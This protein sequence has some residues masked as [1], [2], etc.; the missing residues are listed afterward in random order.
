MKGYY[1]KLRVKTCRGLSVIMLLSSVSANPQVLAEE[2]HGLGGLP[3]QTNASVLSDDAASAASLDSAVS[4]SIIKILDSASDVTV[5]DVVSFSEG[6]TGGSIKFDKSTGTITGCDSTVTSAVIP[7]EIEGVAVTSIGDSAFYYKTSLTDV[8]IPDTVTKIGANSFYNCTALK[9]VS[10]AENV[11]SVG[12]NAFYSSGLT[13]ISLPSLVTV[14]DYSFY[15]AGMS[16]IGDTPNLKSIGNAAFYYSKIGAITLPDSVSYIGN[17]AFYSCSNLKIYCNYNS[18]AHIYAQAKNLNYE[19]IDNLLTYGVTGGNIYIE[20]NTGFI[21]KCDKSVISAIIPEIIGGVEIRG[22]GKNA[23]DGCTALTELILPD[24]ITKIQSY[25]ISNCDAIKTLRLPEGLTALESYA[26]NGCD[27]VKSLELPE[28]MTSIANSAIYRCSALK[29]LTINGSLAV[30]SKA[31]NYC[32]NLN[33]VVFGDG[34]TSIAQYAVYQANL[35]SIVI[36]KTV[37]E[38][39]DNAFNNYSSYFNSINK[40]LVECC[41]ETAGEEYA[42][43]NKIRYKLIDDGITIPVDDGSGNIYVSATS[44]KITG[45]DLGVKS[46][47][48]N[49]T[50]DGVTI[51]SVGNASFRYCTGL[52][53]A[54]FD[55]NVREFEDGC[56][57][58]CSSL[59]KITIMCKDA[60]VQ[61][62]LLSGSPNAVVYCTSGS[63][64]E[65]Y[66]KSYNRSYVCV[67]GEY[68]YEV[69]GGFI[70]VDLSRGEIVGFSGTPTAVEIPEEIKGVS[71]VGVAKNAFKDCTSLKSLTLPDTV[72]KI[73][74]YAFSGCNYM[75]LT[76]LPKSVESIGERA[77]YSCSGI[78][79]SEIP[80]SVS[81]IGAYAFANS[82]IESMYIG[83][84]ID[85]LPEYVFYNCDRLRSV[86]VTNTSSISSYVFYDCD[87]LESV[88]F[89]DNIESIGDYAFAYCETLQMT[90]L[91]ATITS[92]GNY[93]FYYCSLLAISNIPDGV[94]AIGTYTFAYTGIESISIGTGLET[95]TGFVGCSKLKSAELSN[96]KYIGSYAFNGCTALESVTFSNDI[97]SIGD[98]AF[99]GCKVLRLTTLPETLTSI[100]SYAFRNCAVVKI[101]KIPDSV[102]SI[103]SGAFA[104]SGIES[105][106]IGSGMTTV[107]GFG[108]CTN[109]K[110]VDASNASAIGQYAFSGCTALEN[111]KLSDEL[112]S[113]SSYAFSGCKAL[114]LS[115]LPEKLNIIGGYAFSNSGIESIHMGDCV[116]YVGGYSF[117]NCTNLKNVTMSAVTQINEYA[118]YNC[119]SLESID[120]PKTLI[121]IGAYAFSGDTSLK[122]VKLEEGVK[123]IYSYAFRN[124]TGLTDVYVYEETQTFYT[125]VFSN[126]S[127]DLTIHCKAG[128]SAQTYAKN[129]SINYVTFTEEEL[130]GTAI[131]VQG[132]NIYV[133]K[134]TGTII[135]ADNT[136]E[137]LDLTTSVG[138]LEIKA[139]ADKAF[140]N[141]INLTTVKLGTAVKVGYRSFYGCSAI[142]KLSLDSVQE[143]G[144]YAFYDCDALTGVT[145]PATVQK[146]G[147]SAFRNCS[148]VDNICI[149]GSPE[150]GAYIFANCGSLK[151]VELADTVKT[152]ASHAFYYCTSL[153][154]VNL[155][156]VETIGDGAFYD[157]CSLTSLVMPD[158]VKT[159]GNY[160]F[161]YCYRIKEINLNKVETIGNGAFEYCSA[162]TSIVIPDNVTS[163]GYSTFYCC[164][165]LTSITIPDSVKQIGNYAFYNCDSLKEISL[166]K[167]ET[168]GDRVFY[169]CDSLNGIVI[170]DSVTSI[171]ESVFYYCT[172][173]TSVTIPDS[174]KQIGSNAFYNCYSLKEINLNKV[175]TIGDYAF[176]GCGALTNVVL[177]NTV[178]SIGNYAFCSCNSLSEL[179]LGSVENIGNYAFE[180][181]TL[182]TSVTIP[183]TLKVI[184]YGVFYGCSSLKEINLNTVEKINDSAFSNCTSLK[185]V[186]IPDTVTYIG[187]YA[188]SG[189]SALESISIPDS[190][191]QIGDYCFNGSYKTVIHCSK[192]SYAETYAKA[193]SIK[194]STDEDVIEYSLEG[195]KI[196]IDPQTGVIINAD[197]T[198]TKA[199]I[200]A[201]IEGVKIVDLGNV[202]AGNTVLTEVH[203]PSTVTSIG[204]RE[205]YGCS[206]LKSIELSDGIQTI[207]DYAFYN[208]GLS[209]ITIPDSV[210]DIGNY[211]FEYCSSL[212][213]VKLGNGVE[214]IGNYAF[215]YCSSLSEV[216]LGN[217]VE[218]IGGYAFAYCSNLKQFDLGRNVKTIG[219]NIFY[220][221]GVTEALIPRSVTSIGSYLFGNS[222]IGMLYVYPDSYGLSYASSSNY[223]YK[224]VYDVSVS[225]DGSGSIEPC[226]IVPVAYGES[227]TLNLKPE[228]G[229]DSNVAKVVV[230]G[231]SGKQVYTSGITDSITIDDI[232]ESKTVS[233]VFTSQDIIPV[234]DI[235]LEES[236]IVLE[237]GS[238]SKKINYMVY[239]ED[240]T[241]NDVLFASRDSS[242][243]SVSADGVATARSIGETSFICASGDGSVTKEIKVYVKD[244]TKPVFYTKPEA[245]I[246]AGTTVGLKWGGAGDASGIEKYVVL[247]DGVKVGE[248]TALSYLDTDLTVDTTYVYEVMAVDN[249]GNE[250]EKH[251]VTVT[252]ITPSGSIQAYPVSGTI[253]GGANPTQIGVITS[254]LASN[255]SLTLSVRYSNGSSWISVPQTDILGV[256][257]TGT[258]ETKLA[259]KFDTSKLASGA[260]NVKFIVTGS[261]KSDETDVVYIVD[262]DAPAAPKSVSGTPGELMNTITWDE[263]LN[264]DTAGYFVYRSDSA[265]GSFVKIAKREGRG[266]NYY[267]DKPLEAGKTYYYYVTSYDN[268]DQEG[269]A[270]EVIGLTVL[271]DTKAPQILGLK[272]NGKDNQG[273][274]VAGNI[275]VQVK[276]VDNYKVGRIE[277][278]YSL[279]GGK[280]YTSLASRNTA[281]NEEVTETFVVNTK[282]FDSNTVTF[283]VI[284]EDYY[285]NITYGEDTYTF[286][287]DNIPPEKVTGLRAEVKSTIVTLNWN[288]VTADDFFCFIVEEKT[289]GSFKEIKRISDA[290]GCN[291]TKA[292]PEKVYSYRVCACDIYGNK[293]EYSQE[294]TITTQKDTFS[295]VVKDISPKQSAH[296]GKINVAVSVEDDYAVDYVEIQTSADEQNWQTFVVEDV[297]TSDSACVVKTVIDVSDME[298]GNLF[299]RAVPVDYAGNR[300]D[301]TN[302]TYV[303]YIIDHTAPDAP[304]GVS[305]K[306]ENGSIKVTWANPG[307]DV[308]AFDV[309]KAEREDGAYIRI[310]NKAAVLGI[311]DNNCIREKNYYYYVVAYDAAGN[312]SEKSAIV[313]A[314]V[315]KDTEPPVVSDIYPVSGST[316]AKSSIISVL[317]TDNDCISEA[318]VQYLDNNMQWQD[319]E[320]ENISADAYVI[321]FNVTDEMVSGQAISLRANATDCN[322]N[323]G[324]YKEFGYNV[325]T[326]S[327]VISSFT[328]TPGVES[329]DLFA[330]YADDDIVAIHIY[331][332]DEKN[333]D[334][335]YSLIE[336]IAPAEDGSKTISFTDKSVS[337]STTYSY[338]LVLYNSIGNDSYR[339]VNAVKPV[340]LTAENDKVKPVAVITAPSVVIVGAE[341]YFDASKSS[342]NFGI[343]SYKWDFGDGS[344]S[345]ALKPV[346]AFTQSG[347]Y[348]VKLT[349]TDVAGNTDTAEVSV[350]VQDEDKMGSVTIKVIDNYGDAVAN[351]GVYVNLGSENMY[352][353]STD[354]KGEYKLV[355]EEGKYSVGV[356]SDGYLPA[357]TSVFVTAKEDKA[358]IISIKKEPLVVGELTHRK[359]SLEEIKAAGI[360]ITKDENKYVYNYTVTFKIEETS[361][362]YNYQANNKR[363]Y[364]SPEIIL[365]PGV[366]YIVRAQHVGPGTGNKPPRTIVTLIKIPGSISWVKDF[367]EVELTVVNQ[368]D[369]EFY[370]KDSAVNLNVP[371]G[372]T[373]VE[374]NGYCNA[375]QEVFG[376][377]YGGASHT[378]KWVVRGDKD[379]SYDISADFD[380]VLADFN[381]P[382]HFEFKADEPIVVDGASNLKMTV[383][384]EEIVGGEFDYAMKVGITNMSGES[385]SMQTMDSKVLGL[386]SVE[387][388]K[389]TKN[390]TLTENNLTTLE[391]GETLWNNYIIPAELYDTIFEKGNPNV[392]HKVSGQSTARRKVTQSIS[393]SAGSNVELPSSLET[394][395]MFSFCRDQIDVYK[396]EGGSIGEEISQVVIKNNSLDGDYSVTQ[397]AY[398][399]RVRRELYNGDLVPI[400]TDVRIKGN[401]G[402]VREYITNEDGYVYVDSIK[403]DYTEDDWDLNNNLHSVSDL[404]N[405]YAIKTG[406]GFKNISFVCKDER[407][408]EGR[409]TGTL[410]GIKDGK[411]IPASG[412]TITALGVSTV[413]DDMGKF[414]LVT[415]MKGRTQVSIKGKYEDVTYNRVVWIRIDEKTSEQITIAFKSGGAMTHFDEGWMKIAGKTY[416]KVVLPSVGIKEFIDIEVPV[417]VVKTND[418]YKIKSIEGY[419]RHKDGTTDSLPA[420]TN[421]TNMVGKY[422]DQLGEN[423]MLR[424][425]TRTEEFVPGDKIEYEM[426]LQSDDGTEIPVWGTPDFCVAK[427]LNMMEQEVSYSI[428][429]S[430]SEFSIGNCKVEFDMDKYNELVGNSGA[431]NIGNNAPSDGNAAGQVADKIN[432]G[433]AL[434][435]KSINFGKT[436]SGKYDLSGEYVFTKTQG[437]SADILEYKL[438]DSLEVGGEITQELHFAY[439]EE[440]DDW[441]LYHN[442]SVAGNAELGIEFP[443]IPVYAIELEI[444]LDVEGEVKVTWETGNTARISDATIKN[445]CVPNAVEGTIGLTATAIAQV[446]GGLLGAGAY[447]GGSV[448]LELNEMRYNSKYHRVKAGLNCGFV[449]KLLWMEFSQECYDNEWVVYDSR[450]DRYKALS[451]LGQV[452]DDVKAFSADTVQNAEERSW[453]G[454][455][456][457]AEKSTVMTGAYANNNLSVIE[458]DNGTQLMTF[459]DY[460]DNDTANPL[461]LKYSINENGSWSTPQVVCEDG[462]VDMTPVLEKTASGARVMWVNMND[463]L[464]ESEEKMSRQDIQDNYLSRLGVY[465]ADFDAQAGTWSTQSRVSDEGKFGYSPV[466]ATDGTTVMTAY[467]T[468]EGLN[469]TSESPAQLRFVYTSGDDVVSSGAISFNGYSV[470]DVNI[471]YD[472]NGY[473]LV[474]RDDAAS[475][476]YVTKYGANGWSYPKRIS[477]NNCEEKFAS[478]VKVD[479]K[480]VLYYVKDNAIYCK[481]LTDNTDEDVIISGDLTKDIG[482]LSVFVDKQGTEVTLGWY[483]CVDGIYQIAV[484]RYDEA[485]SCY[486]EGIVV[487]ELDA[488]TVPMGIEVVVG[489]DGINVYYTTMTL[490]DNDQEDTRIEH[491]FLPMYADLTPESVDCIN[492]V[493]G[494]ESEIMVDISNLGLAAG[495][496]YTVMIADNAN[497]DNPIASTQDNSVIVSGGKSRAYLSF[498][499]PNVKD[500]TMPELYVVVKSTND[501]N[502][503]NDYISVDAGV[504]NLEIVE[505]KLYE[506]FETTAVVNVRNNSVYNSEPVKVVARSAKTQNVICEKV[507]DGISA[508]ES[509]DV[510]LV[511]GDLP[512]ECYN[513]NGKAVIMLSVESLNDAGSK[514]YDTDML[515]VSKS[516]DG[517]T[518]LA[519]KTYALIAAIGEVDENDA[520]KLREIAANL[521]IMTDEEL[522]YLTNL[523]VYT[524][525]KEEYESLYGALSIYY[526]DVDNDRKVLANDAAMALQYVLDKEGFVLDEAGLERADVDGSGLV[527]SNDAALILQKALNNRFVL[528]VEHAA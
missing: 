485:N 471:G 306:Q 465:S 248:T 123:Y 341:N 510:E 448:G 477:P 301:E 461:R 112:T 283:K 386:N 263:G 519:K 85:V 492:I 25:G 503:E 260:Y 121:S 126:C 514:E 235:E 252:T 391:K 257:Y 219:Y 500:N 63:T 43:T 409:L 452:D 473:C 64:V 161:Y 244:T 163:I 230:S 388:Y 370:I 17:N 79:I 322:G 67:D 198:I 475:L 389:E 258:T 158:S 200:P 436:Y 124:C 484:S 119:T 201:E 371:N 10:G 393:T 218:T 236:E 186:T 281:Q 402:T 423:P 40:A 444:S 468:S 323:V 88:E 526:G 145:I 159:I 291:I 250:S 224:L 203:I 480:L 108:N 134:S 498:I 288:D 94:T 513:E 394:T 12:N 106:Y 48:I 435:I 308:T 324:E 433:S 405:S 427:A 68:M 36:P 115:T 296:N 516:V 307:G 505:K 89:S 120:F 345:I 66:C 349:V 256:V 476:I 97:E 245:S 368:A 511:L 70:Q 390:G 287:I 57:A 210:T 382:V 354:Y 313:T 428:G 326:K 432:N 193:N 56:F 344:T 65:E 49:G 83:T 458:L 71:I 73:G 527:S 152:I 98:N 197:S 279:D 486:G 129:N 18:Y 457:K 45:A 231:A 104:Y 439:N 419:V 228:E 7:A 366:R 426:I 13:D 149:N 59:N 229:S 37:Q 137:V 267:V 220:S 192:G 271:E 246:V 24:T 378:N 499:M 5:S 478:L 215:A 239:P 269:E 277:L 268:F 31:V 447:L 311:Y 520:D 348:T 407:N 509:Q 450:G 127:T 90:E 504:T 342:D 460:V 270:G 135:Y 351:A 284:C 383:V 84:G 173:L 357:K 22:V 377:F 81:S 188:F 62:N 110:S 39:S 456:G 273:F 343:A 293:G 434:K 96:A 11:E 247:R 243:A 233:V 373:I 155:N 105:I 265:D 443:P 523:D 337:S 51:T 142:K 429:T 365:G 174:V 58:N 290:R 329:V 162:L 190:V 30:P 185:S 223:R 86:K 144:E 280:T 286:R 355:E 440:E 109:L 164:S 53:E 132:G 238:K 305:A 87:L 150:M 91:P 350:R 251:T 170:P 208:L 381:E 1:K 52:T 303:Q 334:G 470:A 401:D 396:Y 227:L 2:R 408:G 107:T 222:S 214:T 276:A 400:R 181:C 493:P 143:I 133:D 274:T 42:K 336:T 264:A 328:C 6:V 489:A 466:S 482:G 304:S 496:N 266:N 453:D 179:N 462:T 300:G 216:K 338:K 314:A 410:I 196:Y 367:F 298:D 392:Q 195:G 438:I 506:Y 417:I 122:S 46:V 495:S 113:I 497:G 47:D 375:S 23:F 358:E 78:K 80:D 332:A 74:D 138:G 442:T 101:E 335:Q 418:R 125:S 317:F 441:Y 72:K 27:M 515:L 385:V 312:V 9:S 76:A 213:E 331:R 160:A 413:T 82:G 490:L 176:Y 128:S 406:R 356:Y 295:P 316:I 469:G 487:T 111:I 20:K 44:G 380:G 524:K 19:L 189:C 254:R 285:G 183:E 217:G 459:A 60:N 294:I 118:F 204:E 327:P 424:F 175:E 180:Y 255:E 50:F 3:L 240:A 437:A 77:F 99:N 103:D 446:A 302:T 275:N 481:N 102:T 508:A 411:H 318:A 212:S 517:A 117:Y 507:V 463:V 69:D 491:I 54:Y 21:S 225:C 310:R 147:D 449:E 325:N 309:Y 362:S 139:I 29:E 347:E 92:L 414:E 352:K 178:K 330:E 282:N 140:Q 272:V 528:P 32:T 141:N 95:V 202:F 502:T 146:I 525:A 169:D 512:E 166:N 261:G 14:G 148:A 241:V 168:I 211:A 262:N 33:R 209:S 425:F 153:N 321:R 521:K 403:M 4:D 522:A 191:T 374:A 297:T 387:K 28:S 26:I 455:V 479:D 397:P 8:T 464:N 451:A 116:T 422:E 41:Y 165:A 395:P 16:S 156:K 199:V 177:P 416:D 518:S 384:A 221:S 404:S 55:E 226:G 130:Y 454:Y 75:V 299:V 360:D 237:Y 157:C 430:N 187:G 278:V 61:N 38:V 234:A 249:A 171:G 167:V 372:L 205:F 353:A 431:T 131:A 483:A 289:D 363:V 412:F 35:N 172:S 415:P 100:G 501:S 467:V 154:N 364:G 292:V 182:L 340:R 206:A 184:N 421:T 315:E 207:G 253:M 399:V 346:H 333:G 379:G 494:S 319:V 259:A 339:V 34:V 232:R 398:A 361:Y 93:A 320:R 194:Y 151:S 420:Y 474:F 15:N 242:V 114:K 472:E 376:N 359:M 445:E 136:V 488:R 369:S